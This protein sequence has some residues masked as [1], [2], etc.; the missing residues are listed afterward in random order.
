MIDR[1]GQTWIMNV[2]FGEAILITNQK[3]EE[4]GVWYQNHYIRTEY[5]YKK[6]KI[7]KSGWMSK[8][9]LDLH[10]HEEGTWH[11]V[12]STAPKG[13]KRFILSLLGVKE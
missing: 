4:D 1:I 12:S 13:I 9:L 8:H 3:R 6:Q 7:G 2:S 10:W 5:E 11:S